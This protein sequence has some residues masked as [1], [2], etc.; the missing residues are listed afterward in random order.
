MKLNN[1]YSDNFEKAFSKGSSKKKK[2]RKGN[3]IMVLFALVLMWAVA[4]TLFCVYL[5]LFEGKIISNENSSKQQ[6][7]I[8]MI[9]S[10]QED[11][12]SQAEEDTREELLNEL[13]EKMLTGNGTASMLRGFFPNEIVYVNSEG[14]QF[15]PIVDSLKKHTYTNLIILQDEESLQIETYDKMNLVSKFGIDISDYQGQIDWDILQ[16]TGVSFAIMRVGFRGWGTGKILLDTQYLN[17]IEGAIQAGI[18]PGVYFFTQAITKEEA[19]EEAEF[20]LEN[21][22][23]YTISYPIV[24]DVESNSKEDR[25]LDK[26][27]KEE[28]TDVC[29]A[30]CERIK[31]AGY[32]PMIYGNIITFMDLFDMSRLE[33]YKKWLAHPGDSIY[34]PYDFDIWQYSQTGML[35]GIS[36]KV[37]FDIIFEKEKITEQ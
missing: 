22:N 25:R 18:D 27:T 21:I 33:D 4:A 16:T 7:N 36:E 26:L 37:D 15:V 35:N 5:V 28:R 13:K 32:E 24:F 12:V 2:K 17:N 30:F 11:I 10:D 29:I 1:G 34:F 14:Y 31:E 20:I 23:D 6:E 8:E 9:G 3:A 19:I